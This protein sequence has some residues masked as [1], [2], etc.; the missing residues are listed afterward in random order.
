MLVLQGRF[1]IDI[2]NSGALRASTFRTNSY[3]QHPDGSDGIILFHIWRYQ[4]QSLLVLHHLWVALDPNKSV[5]VLGVFE[6]QN[7]ILRFQQTLECFP[8]HNSRLFYILNSRI[9]CKSDAGSELTG[10]KVGE[11]ALNRGLLLV[12]ILSDSQLETCVN[13]RCK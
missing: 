4:R 11:H 13:H 8:R 2:C 7:D 3:S 6:A 9:E 12:C 5:Q 10:V 1:L